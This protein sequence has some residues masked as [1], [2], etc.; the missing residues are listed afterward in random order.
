MFLQ[1]LLCTYGGQGN[2]IQCSNGLWL[3]WQVKWP[4][5]SSNVEWIQEGLGM[6]FTLKQ[7]GYTWFLEKLNWKTM[8]FWPPHCVHM[9]F[10]TPSLQLA[11]HPQYW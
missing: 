4:S 11:Y 3:D 7:C 10:N 5:N 8:T 9:A 2:H 6:A 1:C